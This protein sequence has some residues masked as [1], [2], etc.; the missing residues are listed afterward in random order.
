M[1]QKTLSL[2]LKIMIIGVALCLAVVYAW[3]VPEL[4]APLAE[5]GDGEFAPLYVPWLVIIELTA[6]P[7][8]AAL[9]LAWIISDNIGRD[10]SFCL[11]NARLLG[12]ISLLA[13]ADA[14]YFFIANVVMFLLGK[15]H[16]GLLLGS[17]IACFAGAV[18]C[19]AA[20]GLSHLVRRAAKLQEQSD[21]TI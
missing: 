2:L 5:A 13:A 17:V 15:N 3:V 14:G 7:I 16:P 20:A 12:V 8:I 21:L 9:V 4:G 1:S 18:I 11:Q 19:V 6:L 10:R